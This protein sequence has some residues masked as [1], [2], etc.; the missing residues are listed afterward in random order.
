[1]LAVDPDRVGAALRP[2]VLCCLDPT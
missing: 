2:A 1:V